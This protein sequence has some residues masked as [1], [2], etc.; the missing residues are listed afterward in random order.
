MIAPRIKGLEADLAPRIEALHR[1]DQADHAVGDEVGL[2][3]VRGQTGPG[4]AG[5]EL[6]QRRVRHDESLA[7]T[8]ISPF[9]V[10]APEL[11]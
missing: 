9:L 7:G 2:I 5:D 10:P 1:L 6:D 8:G 11:P 4:A 3:D